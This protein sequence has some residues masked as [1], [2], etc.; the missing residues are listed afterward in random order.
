MA[1][2]TVRL[3]V[4]GAAAGAAGTTALNATTYLDMTLRGRPASSTP[5]RTVEHLA[6]HLGIPIPGTAA[7]RAN[8]ISALGSLGGLLTGVTFGTLLALVRRTGITPGPVA[9][10]L[11]AS[12]GA[13]I[14]A[15]APMTAL[16]ITNPRDWSTADWLADAVPHLAYGLTTTWVLDHL[17]HQ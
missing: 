6:S 12:A 16:K 15:N 17:D 13:M 8:R 10:G 5:N 3:L 7:Q 14:G 4:R 9:G 2:T 1:S 11:L